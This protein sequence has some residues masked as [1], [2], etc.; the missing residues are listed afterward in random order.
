MGYYSYPPFPTFGNSIANFFFSLIEW[1]IEV[2]L[3]AILNIVIGITGSF[4]SGLNN[5]GYSIGSFMG[6]IFQNSV[7]SFSPFGVLAPLMASAVWGLSLV[8]LIFFVFKM[9]QLGIRET[10]ED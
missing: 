10:E 7:Q 9:I 5:S 2:P 1:I 6:S 4:S 8:I 3:I